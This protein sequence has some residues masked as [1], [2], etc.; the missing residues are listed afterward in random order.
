MIPEKVWKTIRTTRKRKKQQQPAETF[1]APYKMSHLK[2]RETGFCFSESILLDVFTHTC[3]LNASARLFQSARD[4]LYCNRVTRENDGYH[5]WLDQDFQF[6]SKHVL[7]PKTS[8]WDFLTNWWTD[9]PRVLPENVWVHPDP[10]SHFRDA[11]YREI[12]LELMD[13]KG[14]R[15]VFYDWWR[16]ERDQWE[17]L[18]AIRTTVQD[19]IHLPSVLCEG[20]ARYVFEHENRCI[21][22]LSSSIRRRKRDGLCFIELCAG[23]NQLQRHDTTIQAQVRLKQG[24]VYVEYTQTAGEHIVTLGRYYW[25]KQSDFLPISE[26]VLLDAG[27]H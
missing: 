23:L 18:L 15:R 20:I 1:S 4:D 21:S 9:A 19:L 17:A 25:E 6:H 11:V 14:C 3:A 26:M 10:S 5:V 7:P 22:V 27:C 16:E 8:K 2:L 24:N 12:P 13:S